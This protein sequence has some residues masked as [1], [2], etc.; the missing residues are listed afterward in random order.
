MCIR[1]RCLDCVRITLF[2]GS[3]K[4]IR[5]M[6]KSP[7]INALM[8][9][10]GCDEQALQ[11]LTRDEPW[12]AKDLHTVRRAFEGVCGAAFAASGVAR[13]VLTAEYV[14]AVIVTMVK[15]LNWAPAAQVIGSDTIDGTQLIGPDGDEIT[16]RQAVTPER[17][18]A[19]IKMASET[20]WNEIQ[21]GPSAR[22]ERER[23][24]DETD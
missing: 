11:I 17:L 14:A 15:P 10:A 6:M 16:A 1:D 7:H 21:H 4:H 20:D 19:M 3:L 22:D 18:F 8:D 2:K 13:F 5:G 23:G 12:L 24:R 9:A